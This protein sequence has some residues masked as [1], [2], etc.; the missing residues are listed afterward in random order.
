MLVWHY[1]ISNRLVLVVPSIH[2]SSFYAL[3]QQIAA[4][5]IDTL[6]QQSPSCLLTIYEGMYQSKRE[7]GASHRNN[8]IT[9]AR[10]FP[11][12]LSPS[13]RH[14]FEAASE[15]GASC[16]LPIAE[17]GLAMPKGEFRDALC[18]RFGWQLARLPLSCV[19]GKSFNVEHAFSCLCGSFP[20][21][22]HNEIRDLTANL[23]SEVCPDVGAEPALQPLDSEPLQYATA[24]GEDGVRLDVVAR[25]FWGWNRQHAFFDIRVFNPFACSYSHSTLS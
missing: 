7:A 16:C 13:S 22:H 24:N 5:L 3:S 2:L 10:S 23:L 21:I 8:L 14:S 4:P 1:T 17:H 9:F 25:D 19:C 20:T 18:L 6:L 15:H 11:E 12:R